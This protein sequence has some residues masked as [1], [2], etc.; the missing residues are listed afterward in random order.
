MLRYFLF[1]PS[2]VRNVEYGLGAKKRNLLDIYLPN[3]N[4]VKGTPSTPM[5]NIFKLSGQNNDQTKTDGSSNNNNQNDESSKQPQSPIVIFVT[6]GAWIIGY[7]LWGAFIGRGLSSM[8]VLTIIP[9]YRN[10]PQGNVEDMMDDIAAAVHWTQTNAGQY[11]PFQHT[12]STH[13]F[14]TPSRHTLLSY[15]IISL[16]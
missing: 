13:P 12:F 15:L 11:P 9:D 5:Y 4:T 7:K 1:S 16:Y 2:I 6:G 10:F 8:G 3:N 14:I